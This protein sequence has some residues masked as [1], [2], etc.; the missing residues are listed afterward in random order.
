MTKAF[1]TSGIYHNFY[2]EGFQALIPLTCCPLTI[3]SL[4]V[5]SIPHE[6]AK[7]LRYPAQGPELRWGRLMMVMY[8]IVPSTRRTLC[9]E[10]RHDA[11]LYSWVACW[12]RRMQRCGQ[13]ACSSISAILES[14]CTESRAAQPAAQSQLYSSQSH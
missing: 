13:S 3:V 8:G 11:R 12:H 6:E 4:T 9:Q 14:R 10:A 2:S 1:V 5:A 7:E